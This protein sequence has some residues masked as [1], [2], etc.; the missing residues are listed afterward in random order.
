MIAD[1]LQVNWPRLNTPQWA[2]E[3]YQDTLER[4]HKDPIMGTLLGSF[5]KESRLGSLED[6]KKRRE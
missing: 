2:V 3:V 6:G 1:V 4:A 5:A